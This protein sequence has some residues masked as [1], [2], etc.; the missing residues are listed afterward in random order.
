MAVDDTAATLAFRARARSLVAVTT[1]ATT[2]SATATGYARAAGSFVTDGFA[3]GMEITPSGFA[4]NP[5][6]VIT[7][8]TALTL[9][10]AARAVEAAAAGRT[11]AVGLPALR[12][13][14]NKDFTRVVGRPYIDDEYVPATSELR[15]APANGG[16]LEETG[17]YI[18][19]WFGIPDRGVGGIRKPLSALKLLFTPGTSLVA[20]DHTI[21]VRGDVGPFTG[22]IIPQGSGWSRCTLTIPWRAYSRNA[23]AA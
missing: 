2:L 10:T 3:V 4:S 14:E 9:T 18:I 20:G 23:V 5:V 16:T 19:K 12:A 6:A 21:R 8:V 22:Q 13:W 7:E 15:T 11:I 17:L 1:G